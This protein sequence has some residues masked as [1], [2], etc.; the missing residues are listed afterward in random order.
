MIG[1]AVA[2]ADDV[3]DVR[4]I[5]EIYKQWAIQK[6]LKEMPRHIAL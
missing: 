5:K 1:T 3:R 6:S 4:Q 2:M